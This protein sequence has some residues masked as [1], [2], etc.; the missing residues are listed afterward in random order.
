MILSN[1]RCDI[2][3]KPVSDQHV[4]EIDG[5]IICVCHF[6]MLLEADLIY[7]GMDNEWHFMYVHEKD[8][9]ELLNML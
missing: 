8:I 7:E 1:K 5:Y 3:G 2:C 9:E 4:F 6:R